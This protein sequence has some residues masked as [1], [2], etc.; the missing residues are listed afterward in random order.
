[1]STGELMVHD[2]P[3]ELILSNKRIVVNQFQYPSIISIN[4]LIHSSS[5]FSKSTTR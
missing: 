2:K 1:A 5:S 4:S 3:T